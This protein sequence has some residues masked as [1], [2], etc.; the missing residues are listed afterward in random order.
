MRKLRK[1]Q[2]WM[3]M[4]LEAKLASNP[5]IWH[6]R[7]HSPWPHPQLLLD[8]ILPTLLMFWPTQ[9]VFPSIFS[10]FWCWPSLQLSSLGSLFVEA[11]TS[12][13]LRVWGGLLGQYTQPQQ[14][15][16]LLD[17]FYCP[18]PEVASPCWKQQP[19][20]QLL[21]TGCRL[22][23]WGMESRVSCTNG[24]NLKIY[25]QEFIKNWAL[26]SAT[27]MFIFNKC[28]NIVPKDWKRPTVYKYL[29]SI[30]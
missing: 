2:S 19:L 8:D 13:N 30:E 10:L 6:P 26:S 21:S 7:P 17:P 12:I 29:Q 1:T 3:L 15:F 20:M 24:R 25:T 4:G 11:E 28:W 5:H 16:Y 18:H 27:L 23:S 22:G 9:W 14:G